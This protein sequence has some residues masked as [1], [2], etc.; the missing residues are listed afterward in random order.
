MRGLDAGSKILQTHKQRPGE[1]FSTAF[2]SLR[3]SLLFFTWTWHRGCLWNPREHMNRRQARFHAMSEWLL[4]IS[5][6]WAVFPLLDR[7]VEEKPLNGPILV[8]SF[9]I[10]LAALAGGII[11]REGDS[12]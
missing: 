12:D 2:W 11:L 3:N 1:D 5:V 7:L 9:V 4:E 10:S 6:L 8:W